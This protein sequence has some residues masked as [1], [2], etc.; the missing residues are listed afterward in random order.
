VCGQHVPRDS[1]LVLS[2]EELRVT[3]NRLQRSKDY[4]SSEAFFEGGFVNYIVKILGDY[5]KY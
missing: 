5:S 4:T 2:D 1:A 3:A